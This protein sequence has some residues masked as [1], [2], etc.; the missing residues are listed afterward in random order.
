MPYIDKPLSEM[1][2]LAADDNEVNRL[3]LDGILSPKVQ[4]LRVVSDGDLAITAGQQSHWDILLLD[5]HMPGADGIEVMQTL[6]Q[7]ADPEHR[8]LYIVITADAR[9]SEQDRLLEMGFH[10]FLT[11]PISGEALLTGLL[12]INA[13]P[14]QPVTIARSRQAANIVLD[15]QSALSVLHNDRELLTKMRLQFAEEL[16]ATLNHISQTLGQ[17]HDPAKRRAIWQAVHKMA[18]GCAYTGATQLAKICTELED[19]ID[20]DASL[21]DLLNG[22]LQLYRMVEQ[23]AVAITSSEQ[24]AA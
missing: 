5:L 4:Q 24:L 17:L 14:G 7:A 22:Y 6:S 10:G 13:H 15:D 8:T 12:A 2:V 20:N 1:R 3:F 19:Q 21:E 9:K 18:G 11:K 16:P 23:T